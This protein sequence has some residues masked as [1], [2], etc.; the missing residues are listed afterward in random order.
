MPN[1]YAERI[2]I[3]Q[4]RSSCALVPKSSRDFH[5]PFDSVGHALAFSRK[6]GTSFYYPQ[7]IAPI[8]HGRKTIIIGDIVDPASGMTLHEVVGLAGNRTCP[9]ELPLDQ[10]EIV[11]VIA[12]DG[13]GSIVV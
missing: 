10:A 7:A 8:P 1:S 13:A 9:V 3:C 12:H 11:V 6:V 2:I 4:G 5:W